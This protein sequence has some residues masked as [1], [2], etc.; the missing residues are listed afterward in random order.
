[1]LGE[2]PKRK[3]SAAER[4]LDA[5][6]S[7]Y[8]FFNGF[9]FLTKGCVKSDRGTEVLKENHHHHHHHPFPLLLME[10]ILHQ[11]SHYLQGFIHPNGGFLAGFQQLPPPCDSSVSPSWSFCTGLPRPFFRPTMDP[12]KSHNMGNFTFFKRCV[13][14]ARWALE[15]PVTSKVQYLTPF[16]WGCNFRYPK[17]QQKKTHKKRSPK[18]NS[19]LLG[20]S[21]E[22]RKWLIT[23]LGK[24]LKTPLSKV[25]PLQNG[26]NSRLTIEV[27]NYCWVTEMLNQSHVRKIW[28][29]C[30]KLRSISINGRVKIPKKNWKLKTPPS[31][32]E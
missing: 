2:A 32:V 29:L 21:P 6:A 8:V 5:F 19:F 1:M 30:V 9:P 11:L 28:R 3:D 27:T 18:K 22:L 17:C 14:D 15:N 4:T 7:K 31:V 24:S 16:F 10:A 20:G 12:F 26:L 25:L 13:S 23:M